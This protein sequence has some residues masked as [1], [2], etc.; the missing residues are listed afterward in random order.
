VPDGGDVCAVTIA[1]MSQKNAEFD[2]VTARHLWVNNDAGDFLV[3]LGANG[4]GD[5]L[6]STYAAK[7]KMLVELTANANG[8][9]VD[10]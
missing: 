1:A 7:G 3:T 9:F 8:G 4:G 6:V 10:V 2:S 5:G